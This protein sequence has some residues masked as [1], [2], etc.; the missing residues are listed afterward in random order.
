M[1]F[2]LAGLMILSSA[3]LTVFSPLPCF[4]GLSSGEHLVDPLL[5]STLQLPEFKSSEQLLGFA[6]S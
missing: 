1:S 2:R 6:W 5:Q 3:A 4:L